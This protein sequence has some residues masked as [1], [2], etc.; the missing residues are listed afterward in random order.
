MRLPIAMLAASVC[1][2]AQFRTSVPLVLAPTTVTDSK[3]NYVDGLTASDLI[4]HDNNVPQPIQMDWTEFPISL[5]VAVQISSNS[6]PVIDKLGGSGILFTQLLAASGGETAILTF[7]DEIKVN[8]DF[9]SDPDLV[10]HS[11]RMLRKRGDSACALDALDRALSMLESRPPQRRRIVLMIAEKR[12]RGSKTELAAVAA[13]AQR[14][15]A[16]I[17]WL[18]FSPFLQPFTEKPKTMEDLKPEAERVKVQKCA[19]CPAPDDRAAPLDLGPGGYMYALGELFRL[20]KPDLSVLFSSTTGGR[21]IG[22]LKKNA[23]EETIQRVAEEVHRQYILSFLPKRGEP[24]EFHSLRVEVKARP[25][26]RARTRAG[27]WTVSEK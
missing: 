20:H 24:G 6:G 3:G 2:L 1:C 21:N 11:L 27:Y 9:T 17:Y 23:L 25:D 19:L 13:R 14:L 22:F 5:V 7:S 4:L 15:N 18:T 8:Q 12:D 10:T 26:L 16:T